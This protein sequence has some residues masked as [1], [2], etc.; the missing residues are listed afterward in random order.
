MGNKQSEQSQR[1]KFYQIKLVD[2][3]YKVALEGLQF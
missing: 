2:I 1:K 3:D